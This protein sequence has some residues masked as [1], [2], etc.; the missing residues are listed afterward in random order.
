MTELVIILCVRCWR[1]VLLKCALYSLILVIFSLQAV[2]QHLSLSGASRP[3]SCSMEDSYKTFP[4]VL[5]DRLQDAIKMMSY[6][7]RIYL[8]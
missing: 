4:F 3:R 8:R 5:Q 1:S 6:S 2:D 7:L